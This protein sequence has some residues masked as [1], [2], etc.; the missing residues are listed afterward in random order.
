MKC[1][2]IIL[3]SLFTSLIMIFPLFA[4][5]LNKIGVVDFQKIL[6]TS[7]VGKAAQKEIKSEGEKMEETLKEK[8]AEIEAL[9]KKL[10]RDALVIDRDTRA[11]RER[12]IRIK[13]NDIKALQKKYMSDFRDLEARMIDRIRTQL[14]DIIENIGKKDGYL[15]IMEKNQAGV[16]YSPNT[17]DITEKVI[18]LYN[19]KVEK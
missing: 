5:N 19:K 6:E 16:L 3:I 9:K 15:L 12:E 14:I 13:I 8:G 7:K 10:E 1:I 2:K 11:E 18:R 17:V 4:D